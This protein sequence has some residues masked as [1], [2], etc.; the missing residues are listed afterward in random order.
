MSLL[1]RIK[2]LIGLETST[3]EW[4]NEKPAAVTVEHEPTTTVDD[5][6]EP[7]ETDA[8]SSEPETKPESEPDDEQS[9]EPVTSING[10]GPKYGEKLD[11][12]GVTT[13]DDLASA[14]PQALSEASGITESRLVR[15]VES[16]EQR[17][18]G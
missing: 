14:D 16:A 6:P 13:V 3:Q 5:T 1:S 12:A 10:I 7:V 11:A 8:D 17:I 4:D 2:R 9:G 18:S 15:W